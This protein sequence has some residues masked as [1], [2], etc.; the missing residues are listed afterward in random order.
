MLTDLPTDPGP[1]PPHQAHLHDNRIRGDRRARPLL[2][3][4]R[5]LRRPFRVSTAVVRGAP[6]AVVVE[7]PLVSPPVA[8]ARHLDPLRRFLQAGGAAAADGTRRP[9]SSSSSS[10]SSSRSSLLGQRGAPIHALPSGRPT[11]A[12]ASAAG[13]VRGSPAGVPLAAAAAAAAAAVAVTIA[14]AGPPAIVPA[15]L[16]GG[17]E[18]VRARAAAARAVRVLGR[19]R[20]EACGAPQRRPVPEV[21]GRA[22][23]RRGRG[24]RPR[25]LSLRA[26][27]D[28]RLWSRRERE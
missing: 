14:I 26:R 8:P 6:P 10:S 21:C 17:P 7:G 25:G 27:L 1:H 19:R 23:A 28:R 20:G 18:L 12:T 5:P 22:W 13:P 11:H 15:R 4:A 24:A 16:S 9:R 3:P 2:L